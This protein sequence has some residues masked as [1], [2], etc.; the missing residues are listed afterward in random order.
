MGRNLVKERVKII[1]FLTVVLLVGALFCGGNVF[2]EE[3]T[4]ADFKA[5]PEGALTLLNSN[6]TEDAEDSQWD[7]GTKTLTLKGINFTTSAENAINLPDGATLVLAD[8][9]TNTICTTNATHRIGI[10]DDGVLTISGNGKLQMDAPTDK[11][12][13]EVASGVYTGKDLIINGGEMDISLSSAENSFSLCSNNQLTINQGTIKAVSSGK[14]S[15]YGIYATKELTI[16]GSDVTASG[17]TQALYSQNNALSIDPRQFIL[18][19]DDEKT[20][21]QVDHY[22]AQKWCNVSTIIASIDETT[23]PD[24]NF[25]NWVI[26]NISKNTP[27]LTQNM[28]DDTGE[29][30]IENQGIGDLTG[31][32]YFTELRALNCESNQLTQ[33]DLNQ[34]H[35]L[36]D[37]NC[38]YNQLETLDVRKNESLR[39][40][41]CS[42]NHLAKLDVNNNKNL[43]ALECYTNQ[44][45]QLDVSQNIKLQDLVCPDNQLTQLDVSENTKLK[46]LNCCNNQLTSLNLTNNKL[47]DECDATDQQCNTL[48][49]KGESGHWQVDLSS[50]KLLGMDYSK[51]TVTSQN[52][53]LDGNTGLVTMTSKEKPQHLSY[54]YATD[55]PASETLPVTIQFEGEAEN[56]TKSVAD[57]V[58]IDGQSGKTVTLPSLSEGETYG[59]PTASGAIALTELKIDKNIL[60]YTAAASTMNQTGTITI[61]VTGSNKEDSYEITVTVTS[62]IPIDEKTFPDTNFRN[63]VIKNI[64]KGTTV[65][66]QT[67]IDDCKKIDV[68]GQAIKDLTGINQFTNLENLSCEYNQLTELDLKQNKTL[69]ALFCANNQLKQLDVSLNDNLEDVNCSN[70]QLTSM[71]LNDNK[72]LTNFEGNSQIYSALTVSGT[73][74]NWKVDLSPLKALGMDYSKVALSSFNNEQLDKNTGIV[75]IYAVN[76]PTT[77][78][79]FY[80]TDQQIMT[81]TINLKLDETQGMIQATDTVSV[82]GQQGKTM[83]LP[84][85]PEGA[86]YGEPTASGEISLTEMK[87]DPDNNSLIYTASSSSNGQTGTITVP[88]TGATNY[89]DYAMTVTV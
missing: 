58:S 52:A 43:A 87:I 49:V 55:G 20:A 22:D 17:D 11:G 7:K 19:G 21:G 71:D 46:N 78:H 63:W 45:S 8:G 26:R 6:K 56:T 18:A 36:E 40:L 31:I 42:S 10:N 23:F 79:Y 85:L 67:M 38:S 12:T 3:T 53:Q 2:A 30:K 39:G 75:T 28:I 51:V 82:K 62:G 9:T 47:L 77:L 84:K 80:T 89:N 32:E 4:T 86:S 41:N 44:L 33:L 25:R 5:D 34:N 69:K 76:K 27:I 83:T 61:P 13:P 70:N 72:K 14:T 48:G 64:A 29:L 81:V 73:S 24:E 59:T 37:L 88:V 54:T 57:T 35:K 68:S 65:L 15:A 74:G 16:N 1:A 66:T 50:L 60:I